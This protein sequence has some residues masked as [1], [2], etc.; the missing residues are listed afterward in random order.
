VSIS[1]SG[2]IWFHMPADYE[3]LTHKST[4][5]GPFA[6]GDA[7]T[8]PKIMSVA[9]RNIF[10]NI[11]SFAFLDFYILRAKATSCT[12]LLNC[13]NQSGSGE[14]PVVSIKCLEI[15]E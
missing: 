15:L 3:L 2:G 1:T 8:S 14:G 9:S 11:H 5:S 13:L 12:L 4:P 6:G 10:L 7:L